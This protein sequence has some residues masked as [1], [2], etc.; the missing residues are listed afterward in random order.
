MY[1]RGS[2]G[3]GWTGCPDPTPW[4]ITKILDLL[5]VLVQIQSQHSMLGHHRQASEMPFK[6]RFASGPM[7]AR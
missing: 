6:W 2:R 4:K 1:M 5:A 3:A 7:I